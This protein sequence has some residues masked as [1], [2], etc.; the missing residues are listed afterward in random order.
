MNDSRVMAVAMAMF[1]LVF[2]VVLV[3]VD[4]AAE[5]AVGDTFAVTDEHGNNIGYVITVDD[6]TSKEVHVKLTDE[7]EANIVTIPETVSYGGVQYTVTGVDYFRYSTVGTL[8][9]PDTIK[10]IGYD[11]FWGT[12]FSG[13]LIIP[14]SVTSIEAYAFED[15]EVT[16][17]MSIGEP[18]PGETLSIASDAFYGASITG[19]LSLPAGVGSLEDC[20]VFAG[21]TH[22]GL[23]MA[24]SESS[25]YYLENG[26]FIEGGGG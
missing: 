13:N 25:R 5:G 12:E 2:G 9:L 23:T 7:M 10:T 21:L 1:V 24:S 15:I 4:D 8:T 16:G 26:L 20:D 18:V 22:G 6:D 11:A 3:C 17:N 19:T 14:G